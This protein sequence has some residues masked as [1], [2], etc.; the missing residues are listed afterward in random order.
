MTARLGLRTGVHGEIRL[1]E[2]NHGHVAAMTRVA[3]IVNGDVADVWSLCCTPGQ[4]NWWFRPGALGGT[5]SA[6]LAFHRSQ[7]I[8]FPWASLAAKGARAAYRRRVYLSG[9]ANLVQWMSFVY[10]L[11]SYISLIT[12]RKIFVLTLD[13]GVYAESCS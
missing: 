6:M 12:E 10:H 4:I 11:V 1:P 8:V 9:T 2:G 7:D 3:N 13:F 5:T